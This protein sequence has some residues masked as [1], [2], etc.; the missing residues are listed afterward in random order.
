MSYSSV[1]NNHPN[2]SILKLSSNSNTVANN[3]SK[4][5]R[6]HPILNNNSQLMSFQHGVYKL[7][8]MC[9]SRISSSKW[10][11]ILAT[12]PSGKALIVHS[13]GIQPKHS[14]NRRVQQQVRFLRSAANTQARINTADLEAAINLV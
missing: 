7:Q 5:W 2:M 1:T 11:P 12:L 13:Q 8:M 4:Y 6:S 9:N 10:S 3:S 14:N